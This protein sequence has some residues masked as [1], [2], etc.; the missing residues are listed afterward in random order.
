MKINLNDLVYKRPASYM[1]ISEEKQILGKRI[2]KNL[3]SDQPIL[4]KYFKK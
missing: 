1:S 4:K 2:N 3:M